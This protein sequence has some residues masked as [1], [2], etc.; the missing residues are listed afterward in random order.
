VEIVPELSEGADMA[1]A[2]LGALVVVRLIVYL[3]ARRRR[4]ATARRLAAIASRLELSD[5]DGWHDADVIERLERFAE[6]A[7]LRVSEAEAS[8]Q[9]LTS[10][11]DE[12]SQGVVICD[13]LGSVAY[14]NK[15][16][17]A[18]VD[19]LAP[20]D[21]LAQETIEEVLDAGLRGEQVS[22]NVEVLGPPRLTLV[23]TGHPVDDGRRVVGSFALVEDISEHRRL[24]IIRKDFLANVTSELKTPIGAL[25]LLAGTLVEEKDPK[26]IRR[27]GERLRDESLRMGQVIDDLVEMGRLSAEAMPDRSPVPAHLIVAQAV[28]EVRPLAAGRKVTIEGGEA[29]RRLNVVGDRR[30]LVSAVRRLVENAVKFTRPGSSVRLSVRKAGEWVEIDVTDHGHGIP[31]R[32]LD[33]IFE[34][35][36]R[37]DP[38]RAHDSGGVGLGLAIVWQ[39]AGVHG[40]EVR[41][42]TTEGEGS[43]F[44]LRLPARPRIRRPASLS[45]AG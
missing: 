26:L 9:R 13:E 28:E 15:A 18:L 41:V 39:V 35:F 4:R 2:V 20:G 23:V 30:Q 19:R 7:V 10:A 45:Q 31:S 44:T 24:D 11:L 8:A 37:V 1:A 25:G 40:G 22:R 16:A 17:A 38:T 32:E 33:R 34:C 36:Y 3:V 43:T 14:R 5:D 21:A 6:L 27:L 29:P 42:S 12:M